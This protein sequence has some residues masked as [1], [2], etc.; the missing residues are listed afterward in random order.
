M[1]ALEH[2]LAEEYRAAS[3]GRRSCGGKRR[4]EAREEKGRNGGRM[5]GG[6][7]REEPYKK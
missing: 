2:P 1:G 6:K 4:L 7:P 5:K 3:C